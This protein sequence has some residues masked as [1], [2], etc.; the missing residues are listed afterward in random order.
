MRKNE[1]ATQTPNGSRAPESPTG[2]IGFYADRI[3]RCAKQKV[4]SIAC[5]NNLKQLR[6]PGF[7]MRTITTT[8]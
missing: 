4:H 7:N 1:T 2:A 6:L 8:Q 5:L 3:V